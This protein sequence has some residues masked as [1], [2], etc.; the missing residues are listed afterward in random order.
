MYVPG[1]LGTLAASGHAV[2][3]EETA[4]MPPSPSGVPR[5]C[6]ATEAKP[7]GQGER[8]VLRNRR[9]TKGAT[10]PSKPPKMTSECQRCGKPERGYDVKHSYATRRLEPT[11][12]PSKRGRFCQS[13]SVE[14]ANE[15]NQERTASRQGMHGEVRHLIKDGKEVLDERGGND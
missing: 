14:V 7:T 10:M 13:C 8:A 5:V 6:Q 12:S 3:S 9:T 11:R 2:M 15:Q 1:W 4:S